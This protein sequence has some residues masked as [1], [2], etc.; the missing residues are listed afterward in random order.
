[1]SANNVKCRPFYSEWSAGFD[2]LFNDLVVDPIKSDRRS[3][4]NEIFGYSADCIKADVLRWGRADFTKPHATN[5]HGPLS[6][7]DK[8][9]LYCY[10]NFRSHFHATKYI[11]S[12]FLEPDE[13]ITM[14]DIGAGPFTS[15]FSITEEFDSRHIHYIAVDR[16]PW[17]SGM[18]QKLQL[19]AKR[20]NIISPNAPPSLH[21]TNWNNGTLERG[22]GNGGSII[23]NFSYFFA[24]P[25]LNDRLIQDLAT[26]ILEI[27][28]RH[29]IRRIFVSYADSPRSIAKTR[30]DKFIRSLGYNSA[31]LKTHEVVFKNRLS[32]LHTRTTEFEYEFFE[33]T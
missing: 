4:D 21:T 3:S 9:L 2:S 30:Y 23:F 32:F 19:E 26:V 5:G 14:I 33:L 11:F 1:M 31:C 29:L 6:V 16:S 24:N 15:Y 22:I 8:C 27:R 20:R 18:G 25:S 28:K 7:K 12:Q 10:F 17:M 13:R